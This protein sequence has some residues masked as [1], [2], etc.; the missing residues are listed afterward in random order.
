MAAF[1][2]GKS[3][4]LVGDSQ[5]QGLAPSLGPIAAAAGGAFGSSVH[6]GMSLSQAVSDIGADIFN[7]RNTVI[8][9][10]GG[11]N[12]PR[13]QSLANQQMDAFLAKFPGRQV[14]WITV[15][16]STDPT[17]QPAR[18]LMASWQKAHLPA[19]GVRVIDGELLAKSL[20]RRD[21]VHLTA[22]GYR[23]LAA[24]LNTLLNRSP[25]S[26]GAVAFVGAL[27]GA[28]AAILTRGT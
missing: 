22:L 16:P 15:L 9:S 25:M 8:V 4:E 12:P 14:Y 10:L 7:G 27:I 3:V 1:F 13:T 21:E 23:D 20:P 24:R 26:A 6:P 18:A 17:M 5:A 11:N 28:G 2:A 19:R